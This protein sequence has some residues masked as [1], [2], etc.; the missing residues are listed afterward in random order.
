MPLHP[1]WP[2]F[3]PEP[4][5]VAPG[6][7]ILASYSKLISITGRPNDNW[8]NVYNITH[9]DQPELACGAGHIDQIRALQPGLIHNLSKSD[10]ARFLCNEGYIYR[11][12]LK[13]IY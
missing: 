10:Y 11:D 2:P 13:F 5:I 1:L 4:D 3:H 9:D 12:S 8:V 7:D 6:V